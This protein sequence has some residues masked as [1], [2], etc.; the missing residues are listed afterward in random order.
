MSTYLVNRDEQELGA[1]DLP[2]IKAG[3]QTGQ[4][5]NSD[6]GWQEGMDDWLPLSTLVSSAAPA[7]ASQPPASLP[8]TA[9]T[10]R[11]EPFNPY[12]SP[13]AA[14]VKTV[15]SPII[16]GWVPQEVVSELAGTKPW[17]RFLS[18]LGW[19]FGVVSAGVI[20][21]SVVQSSSS[22]NA[23]SIAPILGGGILMVLLAYPTVK[24]TL[25]AR[26]IKRL[27]ESKSYDD[28]TNALREQRRLWKFYGVI[29]AIYLGFLLMIFL[30]SLTTGRR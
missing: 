25:Y 2:Q 20:I 15:G 14:K 5:E 11:P 23:G 17:V 9:A 21:L 8:K 12:A 13:A 7:H 10:K 30:Y 27:V 18:V 24:L 28:L 19:I 22:T 26:H 6:W 16:S 29:A 4:F 3:L 1:F